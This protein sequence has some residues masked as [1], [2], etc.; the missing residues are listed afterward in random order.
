MFNC[1][2]TLLSRCNNP[3]LYLLWFKFVF[4]IIS[5][6]YIRNRI[7]VFE[8]NRFV[9]KSG[10]DHFEKPFGCSQ[11]TILLQNIHLLF[12]YVWVEWRR[13]NVLSN[14]SFRQFFFFIRSIVLAPTF[15]KLHIS[16]YIIFV[17]SEKYTLITV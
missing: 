17:F 1:K 2:L 11:Q 3:P 8:F 12:L 16:S 9:C 6:N 5:I 10:K 13:S 4:F 14:P 15:K 7:N